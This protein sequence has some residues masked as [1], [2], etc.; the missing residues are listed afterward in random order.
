V[1]EMM[2]L[3]LRSP[4]DQVTNDQ[5]RMAWTPGPIAKWRSDKLAY[6]YRAGQRH[7]WLTP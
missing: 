7:R 3:G 1:V 6:T 4:P 5:A 2:V